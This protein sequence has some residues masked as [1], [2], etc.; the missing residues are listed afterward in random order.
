MLRAGATSLSQYRTY[1]SAPPPD[2]TNTAEAFKT[3]TTK[4]VFRSY[5][6]YKM[7]TFE[8]LVGRSQ[9]VSVLLIFL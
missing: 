6:V 8:G 5:L 1:G 3:K 7:F 4:E 2:F 9:K